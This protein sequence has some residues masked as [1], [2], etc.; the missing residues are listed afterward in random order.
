MIPE[1]GHFALIL[2]L[3]LALC[4][5]ILPLV[6][7]HRGDAALMALARP[8]AFGQ[9]AFVVFAFGCLAYAFLTSDFTVAYVA[10]HSH[11]ALPT[12]YKFSAIWG[13]HEGSLLLWILL[14]VKAYQGQK[15]KLPVIGDMA[16][17][18]A[19]KFDL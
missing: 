2:A 3:G 11:L 7:A 6:G 14:M 10:N 13:A 18:W 8:A 9:L 19:G 4:Q 12:V 5:A 17:E 15:F 1:V 16:E